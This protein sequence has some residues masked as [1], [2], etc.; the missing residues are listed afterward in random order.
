MAEEMKV[1]FLLWCASNE[2]HSTGLVVAKPAVLSC[3]R[4][5]IWSATDVYS[6]EEYEGHQQSNGHLIGDYT[7]CGIL[8]VWSANG[9]G[10]GT[11]VSTILFPF[12]FVKPNLPTSVNSIKC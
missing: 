7:A 12:V 1:D 10:N 2:N 11:P 5:N 6:T 9:N 8:L 4:C 3:G